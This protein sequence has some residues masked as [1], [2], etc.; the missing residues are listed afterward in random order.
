MKRAAPSDP[1]A[2]PVTAARTDLA[3]ALRLAVR[4]GLH[5]GICNHF[6]LALPDRPGRFLLNP[7]GLHWSEVR[8][9]DL[10]IV[11]AEGQL[12]QGRSAPEP[13]AFFIHS[14]IHRGSPRA[15]CVMHTHMPYATALTTLAHGRLEWISQTSARFYGQVAYYDDY[16]G[17]ALDDAEGDRICAALGDKKVL[18]MANHGVVV[19]GPTVAQAFTDLYYLERVCQ[20]QI[21]AYHAGKPLRHL[22]E[23]TLRLTAQQMALEE[24]NALVHFAALKRLLDRDE[25]DYAD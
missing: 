24:P 1:A 2:D 14:R 16:N 5:E 18:F 12:V 3:A 23:T 25:P 6:S 4:Y 7:Y 11:D 8:R 21:L 15:A 19:V 10:L 9:R 13:T 20:L 17:L 22:P